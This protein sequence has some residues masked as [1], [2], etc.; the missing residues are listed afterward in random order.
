MGSLPDLTERSRPTASRTAA[1][2]VSDPHRHRTL[3]PQIPV[4]TIYKKEWLWKKPK[5]KTPLRVA[6]P[7]VVPRRRDSA[8]S[9][10]GAASV[11]KL[12]ARQPPKV[13]KPIVTRFTLLC[14]SSGLCATALLPFTAFAGA[15]AAAIPLAIMHAVAAIVAPFSP[16]ILQKTGARI[17]ISVA[18]ILVFILLTA[19]TVATPL[20]VLLPLY[21]L[22]GITLSPMSLALS[23]SATS[24]AQS[25]G[26]EARRKIALRRALRALRAAQDLGLVFG[27][28]LLG[29]A[30]MIWPEDMMSSPEVVAPTNATLS[31]WPPQ[32]DYFLEDEY[33]E[34]TCGAAGCPS[35]PLLS[36]TVLS[37][38]GRR[39]LV[40]VWASVAL[41]SI[42]LGV[43][44][45][46]STPAPPPDARSVV[47]DPRALLGAPMG[48]F[49]GLQQGFIYTSYIKWYGVCVGGWSCAWRALFG[50]GCLQA[51]AAATLSMAAARGRRGALTA[52]GAAAHAS[53]ML[54]LLRWRAA[55]T[56]LALPAVAAAAWGACAALWDVLQAGLCIGGPGW[57]GPWSVTLAARHAG[58]ALAC[59][60]RQL[61]CVRAQLAGLA[62]ALCAALASQTALELRL[63][64]GEAA[65]HRS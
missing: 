45:A 20:S 5:P 62:T 1:R 43:Y 3:I 40:A 51:L 33:E 56:D 10:V 26:D 23:A 7:V 52:G 54:A 38:A 31:R 24:L 41:M 6:A 27:S 17:V 49:I 22:C 47:R 64:R 11:R 58:L 36:G 21:A 44:G 13:P 28:L 55:R 8:A 50:A 59:A 61:F 35:M 46:T 37:A 14:L 18:H 2:T 42:G 29:G 30:L 32:E 65:R 53:L 63:R 25:A 57:R 12:I 16:L 19:H 39:I 9:S 15:E 4:S 60:A 34:Q 48:L